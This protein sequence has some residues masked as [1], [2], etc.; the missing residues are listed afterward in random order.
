[1]VVVAQ[2]RKYDH[3]F[4]LEEFD[5]H[6]KCRMRQFGWTDLTSRRPGSDAPISGT[7]NHAAEAALFADPTINATLEQVQRWDVRLYAI[8][9]AIA[10]AQRLRPADVQACAES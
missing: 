4:I 2:L 3:V 5:A 1:M 9:R 8:A 7:N 6:D 10:E